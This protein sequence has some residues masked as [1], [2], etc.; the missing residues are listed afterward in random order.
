MKFFKVKR[1]LGIITLVIFT[2]LLVFV[3]IILFF[4]LPEPKP[5]EIR[6]QSLESS[7][8][9][10]DLSAL[11]SRSASNVLGAIN[12]VEL[13]KEFPVRK[14]AFG[15]NALV[16][17]WEESLA[18][19]SEVYAELKT[20]EDGKNWSKWKDAHEDEDSDGKTPLA[21]DENFSSLVVA[22]GNYIKYRLR[23]ITD[24]QKG[25][26]V[27]KIKVIYID[28]EEDFLE[29]LWRGLYQKLSSGPTF[30][31][32]AFA[33]TTNK[34]LTDPP[35]IISRSQW[36]ADPKL[37]RWG[38]EYQPTKKMVVHHTVTPNNDKNPAAT[39]RAIYYFHAVIRK[40]GDIGYNFIIDQQGRI[41]EG[42]Y[43]GDG[44]VG[45]HV[46]HYNYGSVG[47]AVL[48]DYRSAYPSKAVK[49]ALHQIAVWKS[50]THGFDP[51]GSSRFGSRGYEKT[52]P[53]ITYHGNLGLTSC[54][55]T[56]L[57][58]FIPQLRTL[59][60]QMPLEVLALY[61]NGSLRRIAFGKNRLAGD[62][63]R[64]LRR[65]SAIALAGPN[66]IRKQVDFPDDPSTP[67]DPN[68]ARQWYLTSIRQ[69]QAWKYSLGNSAVKVAVLDTGVAYEDHT[70][71][72]ISYS[73]LP[74]FENTGFDTTNAYD[75]VNGDNHANDDNGHGTAVASIIA[76]STNN[77]LV[78]AAI[79]PGVTILPIK[80]LNKHGFGMDSDIAKGISLA[81][82]RGAK[83][84]NLSFGGPDNSGVLARYITAA[85][86]RGAVV[87]AAAGNNA[88]ASAFYPAA[89]KYVL[90]VGATR[91]DNSRAYY[92][93]YGTWLDLFAPG[94]DTRVDLNAD[95]AVDGIYL[96][97]LRKVGSNYGNFRYAYM[98]GTSFSA[99][100]VSA[101]AALAAS[102][103][104]S[105]VSGI[106]SVLLRS[107][108]DL[109]VKGVD[110]VY[111]YGLLQANVKIP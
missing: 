5:I 6:S 59:S 36:R 15:F 26:A 104:L 72:D 110:S 69:D 51:T 44:V 57:I 56:N 105:L 33:I 1:L 21:E 38:T 85:R 7:L 32:K 17:N 28:S 2:T 62:V 13:V 35:S 34:K 81:A 10:K 103:G 3:V 41:Y 111:R 19:G 55:G 96:P 22:R 78:N 73:K 100:Q 53:N 25:G 86:V 66:Y 71:G 29:R 31:R 63:L 12:K 37:M 42:R 8:P 16:F 75:F 4:K 93:N 52:F 91:F 49:N 14:T 94:G 98:S 76:S 30:V 90:G 24:P 65:S 67:N 43:G 58:R 11:A 77:S 68:F 101:V 39:V 50:A 82:D 106:E 99:A 97:K 84:I 18:D 20:S 95:G 79:A 109:G 60:R 48:G 108:K 61:K 102:R 107:T 88:S 45:G 70:D 87:I 89:L 64:D 54:A 9:K 92:S 27:E 74:D 46:Y 47:V 83:V 80:V 40:W 23:I